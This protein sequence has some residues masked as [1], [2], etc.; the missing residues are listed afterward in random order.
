MAD[1]DL[2]HISPEM[3]GRLQTERCLGYDPSPKGGDAT[4]SVEGAQT[5]GLGL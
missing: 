4:S 2:R 5:A 3:R 1:T